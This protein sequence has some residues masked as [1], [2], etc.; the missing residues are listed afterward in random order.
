VGN[1][2]QRKK[3]T[4]NQSFRGGNFFMNYGT[5]WEKG[6]GEGGENK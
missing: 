6:K 2:G 3:L 4:Q 1:G 5:E